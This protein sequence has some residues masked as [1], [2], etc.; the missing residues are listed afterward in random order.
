ME[1]LRLTASIQR[2]SGTHLVESIRI[3]IHVPKDFPEKYKNAVVKA[4]DT[5]A[6]KRHL[7]K[8]P[9]IHIIVASN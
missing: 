4:A 1:K 9:K 8:P 6:V 5:C 7:D 3:D 2:N